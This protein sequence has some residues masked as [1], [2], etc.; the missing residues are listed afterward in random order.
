ML[1][2]H[3]I[4][5]KLMTYMCEFCEGGKERDGERKERERIGEKRRGREKGR[6]E[7]E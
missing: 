5:K 2:R 1:C 7:G 4:Q 6:R 3:G